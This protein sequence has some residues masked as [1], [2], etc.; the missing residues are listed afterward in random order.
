MKLNILP[1]KTKSE[2][3]EVESGIIYMIFG[4]E[5]RDWWKFWKWLKPINRHLDIEM[6]LYGSDLSI[7]DDIVDEEAS[8]IYQKYIESK[9]S[10]N[11]FTRIRM[12]TPPQVA[13]HE[14]IIIKEDAP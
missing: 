1:D 12:F 7:R 14:F 11:D 6:I 8:L 9:I 5:S 13:R 2:K 4:H 3:I 10:T